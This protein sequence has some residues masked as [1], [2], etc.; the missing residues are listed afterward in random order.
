[1]RRRTAALALAAFTLVGGSFAMAT[2]A[3]AIGDVPPDNPPANI[4]PPAAMVDACWGSGSAATCRTASLE[5]IDAAR[6]TEGVGP[7]TLP[8]DYAS[9][10]PSERMLVVTDLER[11]ARGLTPF[12]GLVATLDQMAEQ[13][14]LADED[15]TYSGNL[16]AAWGGN[17]AGGTSSVLAT[18]YLWMYDDGPGGPNVSCPSPG[19]PGCWGHRDNI[20]GAFPSPMGPVTNTLGVGVAG[21]G[22]AASITSLMVGW[23]GTPPPMTYTWRQALASYSSTEPIGIAPTGEGYL[24]LRANGGVE[25]YHTDWFGSLA[26]RLPLGV[27][28]TGIAAD[29]A[30]G[31]YWVLTSEGGVWNF[32]AP[33]YGS[34]KAAGQMGPGSPAAVGIVSTGSGYLVLRANGGVENYHTDWFGSLADRLPPGVAATGIAADAATGGYW[35]LT[36]EGGVWNFDA[37]WYGSPKAGTG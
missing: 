11:T 37:P 12:V 31:G 8:P 3:G 35:V 17:W 22:A 14:A 4:A 20:L 34:P 29:A 36:S 19:A 5:A 15:P 27:A 25:N 23:P 18:M 2:P 7:M 30:T 32:D 1:M 6:A 16:D 28:A 24:V 9:L 21:S 26:D 13:A 33:W 10:S